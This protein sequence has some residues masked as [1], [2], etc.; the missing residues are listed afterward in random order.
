MVCKALIAYNQPNLNST[1]L[2]H[3]RRENMEFRGFHILS[4]ESLPQSL[5]SISYILTFPS[6]PN[7][8]QKTNA[9]P[10]AN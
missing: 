9:Q 4:F 10:T 5:Y 2:L 6:L 3:S 7:F 1:L 8:L